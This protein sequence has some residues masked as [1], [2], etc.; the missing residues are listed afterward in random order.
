[1]RWGILFRREVS[2]TFARIQDIPLT[3]QQLGGALAWPRQHAEELPARAPDR[4]QAQPALAPA[5]S[6]FSMRATT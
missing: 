3:H 2:L 6:A 1:M 4:A 5:A